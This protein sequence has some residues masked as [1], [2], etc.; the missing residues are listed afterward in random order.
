MG[1]DTTIENIY[2]LVE[3][4]MEVLDRLIA[5]PI[6]DAEEWHGLVKDIFL[7]SGGLLPEHIWWAIRIMTE[8]CLYESIYYTRRLYLMLI[9]TW[10][11][12]VKFYVSRGWVVP[13]PPEREPT[14]LQ[15][16]KRLEDELLGAF[17]S[18]RKREAKR[19]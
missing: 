18:R 3:R 8:Y 14:T 10:H 17:S 15:V 11:E 12:S 6:E 19:E 2:K 4:Q 7:A 9:E 5:G 16:P 13:T 1:E